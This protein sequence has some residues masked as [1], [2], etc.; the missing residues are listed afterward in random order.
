MTVYT[1]WRISDQSLEFP[2]DIVL[3]TVT[4]AVP[5]QCL[6]PIVILHHCFFQQEE[7]GELLVSLCYQPSSSQVSVIVL[8]ANGLPEAPSGNRPGDFITIEEIYSWAPIVWGSYNKEGV[9]ISVEVHNLGVIC[10]R[11]WV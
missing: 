2:A 10:E 9:Y 8:K 4:S 7:K 6:E 5:Q 11:Q 3:G 1:A